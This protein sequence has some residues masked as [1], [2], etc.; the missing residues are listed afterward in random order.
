MSNDFEFQFPPLTRYEC[1]D[2]NSI[3]NA[4]RSIPVEDG[5]IGLIIDR[6]ALMRFMNHIIDGNPELS[7]Q[8]AKINRE[9]G[10]PHI[11]LIKLLLGKLS[12][13]QE[14]E[15]YL[16]HQIEYYNDDIPD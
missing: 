11:Y 3:D 15:K 13:I 7:D 1:I 5:A 6:S 4:V 9:Q 2:I 16:I 12:E 14:L 10:S 8:I